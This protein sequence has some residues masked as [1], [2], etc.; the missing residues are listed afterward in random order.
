MQSISVVDE[1]ASLC[2]LR[3]CKITAW[4]SPASSPANNCEYF[5]ESLP[6]MVGRL[7]FSL[8]P[9][10]SCFRPSVCASCYV[11]VAKNKGGYKGTDL[12]YLTIYHACT[13]G[14]FTFLHSG[15]FT[16]VPGENHPTP[17]PVDIQVD[18][19]HNPSYITITIRSSKT[20][21]FGTGCMLFAGWT[22][23]VVCPVTALLSYLLIHPASAGPLFI[24]S[25]GWPLT[26]AG[27]VA[28][29][30]AISLVWHQPGP[31]L[32]YWPQF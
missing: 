31:C 12:T 26:Q 10:F 7:T 9:G 25:N 21:P 8:V 28:A 2:T 14:F 5:E 1:E 22:N 19:C 16:V 17:T 4:D 30:R 13:L 20:D 15:K 29:V 6:S 18:C 32:L 3:H 11:C 24:H 27:M 23:D